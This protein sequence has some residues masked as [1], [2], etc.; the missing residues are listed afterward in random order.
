MQI[1]V[2]GGT[3]LVGKALLSRLENERGLYA[4]SAVRK[5][6]ALEREVVAPDLRLGA[7]ARWGSV[8]AQS[9]TVVHLAATLPW[10]NTSEAELRTVN[11]E[12]T[13]ALARA[14]IDAD[15]KRFIF[16]STLGV[17]GITSGNVPFTP[18]SPI[19]P[20]GRYA[21]SKYTAEQE[22]RKLCTGRME[23]VVLRPPVVYGSGV[24]GKIGLLC[25][26]IQSGK[27]LPIGRIESNRR[28]MI[29]AD[30]LV[31]AIILACTRDCVPKLAL[32]P[33]DSEAV[34]TY[35]LLKMIAAAQ[36]KT[37]RVLPIPEQIF[38]CCTMI[39]YLAPIAVRITG[40]VLVQDHFLA[41][42]LGWEAPQT[43]ESGIRK[44]VEGHS[45]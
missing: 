9:D 7:S 40:N 24:Q 3:G 43:L 33:A 11:V 20:S 5:K 41:S 22:L 28:Q 45:L 25:S 14:A 35:S 37:L 15:V 39:P 30:N 10:G 21:E 27:R 2:T 4:T 16:V 38:K 12:G 6:P 42:T 23:L 44:M 26:K 36:G 8:L 17:H 29:S 31:D 32:L 18:E 34:S 1:T 19:R 13:V